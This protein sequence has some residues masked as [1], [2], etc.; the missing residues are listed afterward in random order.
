MYDVCV[1]VCVC[2][3]CVCVYSEYVCLCVCMCVLRVYSECVCMCMT[4]VCMCMIIPGVIC[5]SRQFFCMVFSFL[6]FKRFLA[7]FPAQI[8]LRGL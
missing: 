7:N 6:Y 4:Y 3:Y 1:F 2:A 8:V 5:I